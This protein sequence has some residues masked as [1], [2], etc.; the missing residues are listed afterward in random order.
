MGGSSGR[1]HR[2]VGGVLSLAL[3]L[4]AP[5]PTV[6]AAEEITSPVRRALAATVG[7]EAADGVGTGFLTEDDQVITAAHVVADVETVTITWDDTRMPGEVVRRDDI[8][9]LALIDAKLPPGHA[10]L[11]LDVSPELGEDVTVIAV[12]PF[13]G[14]VLTRGIVSSLP[15]D[16]GVELIQVDAAVNP[17]TSG[18][19]I[20]GE[21][22]RVLG[23]VITKDPT[24]D[25]AGRGHLAADIAGFLAGETTSTPPDQTPPRH[26]AVDASDSLPL[27]VPIGIGA[28]LAVLLGV[29]AIRGRRHR[30]RD[31]ISIRLG[32]ERPVPDHQEG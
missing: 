18:G 12:D 27:T 14:P 29:G 26:V 11:D 10:T 3:T 20:L 24:R 4:A 2:A 1:R 13:D 22:G 17:G 21:D 7:I 15:H 23:L 30:R 5:A 6:M 28:A 16:S 25:D 32:P 9:D 31:D 19:P 8:L